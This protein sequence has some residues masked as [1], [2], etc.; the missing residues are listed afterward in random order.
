MILG[1]D[2][3]S[4]KVDG[5][6]VFSGSVV[7]VAVGL[8]DNDEVPLRRGMVKPGICKTPGSRNKPKTTTT[9]IRRRR[10]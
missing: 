6:G 5:H 4:V 9:V 7:V 8:V 10:L 2:K 1:S 3:P